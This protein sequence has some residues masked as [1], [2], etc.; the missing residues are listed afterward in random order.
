MPEDTKIEIDEE[1][2]KRKYF[3]VGDVLRD[4]S[5]D[6]Y[7]RRS[8]VSK[9]FSLISTASDAELFQALALQK[10]VT[11]ENTLRSIIK[12]HAM[13]ETFSRTPPLTPKKKKEVPDQR[14]GLGFDINEF[15]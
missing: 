14:K 4:R 3:L 2:Q 12:K 10:A 5:C 7:S 15:I 9:R 11:I 13:K 1:K 6:E 8:Y